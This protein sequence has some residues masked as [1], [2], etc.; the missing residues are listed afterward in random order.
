MKEFYETNNEMSALIKNISKNMDALI[1]EK[2]LYF[3]IVNSIVDYA[4]SIKKEEWSEQ[5]I[6]V[7]NIIKNNM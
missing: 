7:L 1:K 2:N 3:T 5:L 4:K 6:E